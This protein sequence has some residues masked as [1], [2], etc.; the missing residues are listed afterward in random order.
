MMAGPVTVWPSLRSVRLTSGTSQYSPRENI[1][2]VVVAGS[3]VFSGTGRLTVSPVAPIAS[4]VSKSMI[5]RLYFGTN[6]NRDWCACSNASRMSSSAPKGTS[7]VCCD[8]S[9]RTCAVRTKVIARSAM[10]C[11]A[12]S[13]RV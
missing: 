1:C 13:A 2:A 3:T 4:E 8:P 5:R 6:P 11:C 7:S 9:V 10:P 12:T